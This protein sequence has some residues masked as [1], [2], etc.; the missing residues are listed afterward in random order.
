[1]LIGVLLLLRQERH[2]MLAP[3]TEWVEMVRRVVAIVV[4]IAVALFIVSTMPTGT[5]VQEYSQARQ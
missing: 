2:G 4:A 5:Q 3:V 1:M